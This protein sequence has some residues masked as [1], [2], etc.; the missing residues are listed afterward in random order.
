MNRGGVSISQQGSSTADLSGSLWRRAR[1]SA[2]TPHPLAPHGLKPSAGQLSGSGA[3]QVVLALEGANPRNRR[4][5]SAP[6]SFGDRG[7]L[8]AVMD[9]AERRGV[10]T[11]PVRE[12]LT[13][14][15]LPRPVPLAAFQQ[16]IDEIRHACAISGDTALGL[17]PGTQADQPVR[18]LLPTKPGTTL[19][20][21][22]TAAVGIDNDGLH[23]LKRHITVLGWRQTA[24]GVLLATPDGERR[25]GPASLSAQLLARLGRDAPHIELHPVP[26]SELLVPLQSQL[27]DL[28]MATER[29]ANV[30]VLIS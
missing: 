5:V 24:R 28:G 14:N 20:A 30:Y 17:F 10:S 27:A 16:V 12:A 15:G 29:P 8:L 18:I 21:T 22:P 7:T 6:A 23:L 9:W 26:M 13:P 2:A 25:L 3:D 19:L 4:R 11:S 1:S